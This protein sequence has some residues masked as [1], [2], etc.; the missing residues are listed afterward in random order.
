MKRIILQAKGLSVE[1]A[2]GLIL[3]SGHFSI[4]EGELVA[5]CQ[6]SQVRPFLPMMLNKTRLQYTGEL[7]FRGKPVNR[8]NP[9]SAMYISGS[10]MLIETMSI[11]E[12]LSVI[13]NRG[14]FHFLYNPGKVKATMQNF[15]KELQLP[16]DADV[17]LSELT[18]SQKYILLLTKAILLDVPI[19]VLDNLSQ[20]CSRD[21]YAW[22]L[23]LIQRYKNKGR[24]F[25]LLS[26]DRNFLIEKCDRIYFCR[27]KRVVDM[28][29]QDECTDDIF[30]EILFGHQI[31]SWPKRPSQADHSQVALE[32]NIAK[33][34]YSQEQLKIYKSEIFGI[35]DMYG[36]MIPQVFQC[37]LEND[38]YK[39]ND[40]EC[41][42]FRAAL[43]NGLA[44]VSLH[45]GSMYFD[46]FSLPENLVLLKMQSLSKRL[47]RNLRMESYCVD[48]YFPR[49]PDSI[50]CSEW[51]WGQL[52][53]LI[54]RWLLTNP[55]VIIIENPP[56]DM[57][58]DQQEE[59]R[60]L[61]Q[62]IVDSG[63]SIVLISS[64]INDCINICD[65][66]LLIKRDGENQLMNL[67]QENLFWEDEPADNCLNL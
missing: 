10:D 36:T 39:L 12:N 44:V 53:L 19:I 8:K 21:H 14:G 51:N 33:R 15:L 35:L 38:Y 54:F 58:E 13:Q 9:I 57:E 56:F 18:P 37:F 41:R 55:K 34:W 28:L 16:F 43:R 32:I 7:T 2:S 1:D 59:F 11:A 26:N 17:P 60:D 42:S 20:Q 66:V 25:I 61:L 63:C 46:C 31:P 49:L 67:A 22:I 64:A 5:F 52:K 27:G 45:Q 3:K 48:K 40:K 30:Y 23:Q 29:F 62:E 50:E 47:V 24:T 6:S 4:Y 65:R